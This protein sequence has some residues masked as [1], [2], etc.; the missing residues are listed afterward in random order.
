MPGLQRGTQ[1]GVTGFLLQ[2]GTETLLMTSTEFGVL[3]GGQD[4][5][6]YG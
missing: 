1:F 6:V 2:S 5:M 3:G 4:G